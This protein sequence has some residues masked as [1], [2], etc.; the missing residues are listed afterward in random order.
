MQDTYIR[1]N[2]WNEELLRILD[3]TAD[4]DEIVHLTS[5]FLGK[6]I[7]LINNQLDCRPGTGQLR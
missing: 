3:T 4:L 2:R 5:E 7:T 1:Y 6:P